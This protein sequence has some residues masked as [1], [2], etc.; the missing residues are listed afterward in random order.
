ME[1][2]EGKSLDR[3]EFNRSRTIADKRNRYYGGSRSV[4]DGKEVDEDLEMI[5]LLKKWEIIK[6]EQK[7]RHTTEQIR[8]KQA[9][10]SEKEVIL[11]ITC[12]QEK[13]PASG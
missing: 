11:A 8:E 4:D 12:K 3:N 6:L 7:L 10:Q 2:E 13:K 5:Y 1:I 9:A